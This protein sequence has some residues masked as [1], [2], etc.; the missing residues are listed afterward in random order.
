MTI[1][2][3]IRD[4]K[5]NTQIPFCQSPIDKMSSPEPRF[6]DAIHCFNED[7]VPELLSSRSDVVSLI[8]AIPPQCNH[9]KA[10]FFV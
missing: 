5:N 6:C 8:Y 1:V 3:E 2:T 9:L 4:L 7:A 10:F